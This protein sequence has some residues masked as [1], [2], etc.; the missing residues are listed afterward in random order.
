M[1]QSILAAILSFMFFLIVHF[2][3]FH[4]FRPAAKTKSLLLVALV[5]LAFFVSMLFVLPSEEDI[6]R[7][8]HLGDDAMR[9]LLPAAGAAFYAVLILAYFNFY[10]TADRSISLRMLMM[11]D[12]RPEHTTTMQQMLTAYDTTAIIV[13]RMDDLTYGG[14]LERDDDRYRVTARGKR[15]LMLFRFP[16]SFLHLK[17]F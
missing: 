17:K 13:G 9:I 16:I 11:T 15:A 2:L 5:G 4:F 3:H 12:A 7:T 14:S 1:L 6:M 8:L 10:L